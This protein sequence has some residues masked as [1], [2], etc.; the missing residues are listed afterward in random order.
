MC[1]E[2][3]Q[4]T[5]RFRFFRRGSEFTA[6]KR[7][8][9]R[10]AM[11]L[12]FKIEIGIGCTERERVRETF[13]G[14]WLVIWKTLY[15]EKQSERKSS[16][17]KES[18]VEIVRIREE[19]KGWGWG[20]ALVTWGMALFLSGCTRYVPFSFRILGISISNPTSST[21]WLKIFFFFFLKK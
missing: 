4:R 13:I 10:V 3:I 7:R 14:A 9:R 18:R 6:R 2:C 12:H 20:M 17:S 19:T 15:K 16:E 21:A 11:L 8:I 5:H 1:R